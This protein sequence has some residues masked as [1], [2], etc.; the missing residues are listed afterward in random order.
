MECIK[1][2]ESVDPYLIVAII[3][4]ISVL[5]FFPVLS[6]ANP[7]T[8]NIFYVA[9]NGNDN[10]SGRKSTINEAKNDGPFATLGKARNA[11]RR[12][13]KKDKTKQSYIVIVRGG[14]YYLEKTFV[15][16]ME[17]S[18]T[19][20][21]PIIYRAFENETPILKGSRG[22]NGF[23][24]Y[25][26]NVLKVN[27]ERLDINQENVNQ[28]FVNGRRQTLARYPNRD[29][30][31]PVGGGFLY[32]AK[33]QSEEKS[34]KVICYE[35]LP[36]NNWKNLSNAEIVIFP[37]YEWTNNILKN[38]KFNTK[39]KTIT[40]SNPATHYIRTGNRYY[41]QNIFEELD[42]PREWY[43]APTEKTLYF[44][45]EKLADTEHA[46]IPV[47]KNLLLFTG[48]KYRGKNYGRPSH[49]RF[50][51]FILEES[52]DSSIVIN[53][54]EDITIA[55][56]I[57]R[58]SGRHGIEVNGG[59]AN[60]IVGNDIYDIGYTGISIKGQMDDKY[61]KSNNKVVSN[62]IHDT[63]YFYKGT[64]SGVFCQGIGN[65]IANNLIY[66]IP[67]VGIYVKGCDHIIEYNHVHD[68]NQETQD[69][70]IIYF[71][72]LDWT[73]RGSVV[74]Y[75]YLH[76]SGGYGRRHG[77]G[78]WQRDLN[79]FGVYLDDWVSGVQV[80]GNII[81]NTV[82]GGVF[83]HGGRDNIV[84]N[85]IIINGGELGQ[86]VFSA[87]NSRKWLPSMFNEIKPQDIQKYPLLSSITS[88]EEGAK[89]AGNHVKRNII[90]YALPNKVLFGIYHSIDY[91]STTSDFNLIYANGSPI[92]VILPPTGIATEKHWTEWMKKGFDLRSEIEDPKLVEMENGIFR[93]HTSPLLKKLGFK[94][95]PY[96]K[97][98]L[99][100]TFR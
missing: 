14:T 21:C 7:P 47:I 93:P 71:A 72:Q 39:F 31:D 46:F 75:N 61:K 95:I 1:P 56:N 24:K 6:S 60:H 90:W 83:I 59:D 26:G 9:T 11:I 69:S 41:F 15:L 3:I 76:N 37:G 28:L 82:S 34:K 86:I 54:G 19:K 12:F 79:T 44:W 66:S 73:Q 27:L 65:T 80:Y 10:W 74:R 67:R 8:S 68:T 48:K 22:L 5:C 38:F 78:N 42:S 57:I 97:I 4:L 63:G 89:M 92:K 77:T 52:T 58:N 64:A 13:K 50:E 84:E 36:L 91:D 70:G 55:G 33:E 88:I 87:S 81:C 2:I 100:K 53:N 62:D 17:D 32:V 18:G 96:S 45:P 99:T 25:Q 29:F 51:K 40:L 35:S 49:I 16:G 85:N 94:Q 30:K 20:S 98:G 43:L 23:R